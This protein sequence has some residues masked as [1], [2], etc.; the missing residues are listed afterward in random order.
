MRLVDGNKT[1]NHRQKY[2]AELCNKVS[3]VTDPKKNGPITHYK[4]HGENFDKL[5]K[6]LAQSFGFLKD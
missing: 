1:A 4:L 5:A 3:T 2:N 6:R